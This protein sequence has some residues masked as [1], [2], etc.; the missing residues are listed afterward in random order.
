MAKTKWWALWDIQAAGVYNSV[1]AGTK[2]KKGE[3]LPTEEIAETGG[4][5]KDGPVYTCKLAQVEAESE[6]EAI[7]VAGEAYGSRGGVGAVPHAE[8]ELKFFK[9]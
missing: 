6:E 7:I 4:L 9:A 8:K 3:T 5:W 1:K 2:F